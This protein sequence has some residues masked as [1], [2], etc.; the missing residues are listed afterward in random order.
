M[1]QRNMIGYP[2]L[3]R[4]YIRKHFLFAHSNIGNFKVAFHNKTT[5]LLRYECFKRS[6]SCYFCLLLYL[7]DYMVL[8]KGYAEVFSSVFCRFYF[9][10]WKTNITLMKISQRQQKSYLLSNY[11]VVDQGHPINIASKRWCFHQL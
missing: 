7:H 4:E 6:I 8:C 2:L 9:Q 3:Y 11:A 1:T 5:C 10:Q